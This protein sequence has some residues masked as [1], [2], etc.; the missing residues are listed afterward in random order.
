MM[1]SNT[2][3]H[4]HW[5]SPQNVIPER[6]RWFRNSAM[7]V[8]ARIAWRTH[9]L[10]V[11]KAPA[12]LIDISEGGA[13]V[14]IRSSAS[15]AISFFWVGLESL[16]CEWVKASVEEVVQDGLGSVYR[17]RFVENCAPGI[18]EYVCA[19]KSRMCE[20]GNQSRFQQCVGV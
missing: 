1:M 4:H 6:R 10:R 12:C 18:I 8:R 13:R 20:T 17:L 14:F 7:Q 3:V 9:G 15:H 19:R 11:R 2:T 5:H 16:P